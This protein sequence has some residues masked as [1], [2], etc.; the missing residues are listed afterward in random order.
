MKWHTVVF[1]VLLCTGCATTSDSAPP[2][3]PGPDAGSL[4]HYLHSVILER[5]GKF[6]E[7]LAALERAVEEDPEALTLMIRLMWGYYRLGDYEK[8]LD[9]SERTAERIPDDPG[10]WTLRGRILERL[11]RHDESAD[12]LRRAATLSPE[13]ALRDE[14]IIEA[15]LKSNDLVGA[16]EVVEGLSEAHPEDVDLRLRL[17]MV[18]LEINDLTNARAELERVVAQAPD[19]D[20]AKYLL[21]LVCLEL[22]DFAQAER[23]MAPFAEQPDEY[24]AAPGFLA[25][26]MNRQGKRV[27]A[28]G[29][30][31]AFHA[32][33]RSAPGDDIVL[34]YLAMREKDFATAAGSAPPMGAPIFGTLMRAMV[35]A[36]SGEPAR[37][38]LE[39]LDAVE[40]DVDAEIPE[41]FSDLR[42][43][44][45]DD[46]L[47][48]GF[49]A[50]FERLREDGRVSRTLETAYVRIQ[51][52]LDDAG[53][54]AQVA[55]SALS[56]FGG[57]HLLHTYGALAYERLGDLAAA[58]RHLR[59]CL[60]LQPDDHNTMNTLGYLLADAD[61]RLDEAEALVVKALELDPNN[62]FY[63]DSLGW[64]YYRR[65]EY[66]KAIEYIR[67]ALFG[68]Q[69]DDP[70][71]R[72][73]LGD[74]Y[75]GAGEMEKALAEWEKAL[76]LDPEHKGVRDKIDR[77]RR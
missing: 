58:E 23:F 11:E 49:L 73:H 44:A 55:E 70:T 21:G 43:A 13:N 65:G 62:P 22:D 14:A 4:N 48:E 76:R 8:A 9:V 54:A 28:L 17:A 6:E 39:T 18:Y 74:A 56:H 53:K 29:V 24:D 60:V 77:A 35:R 42:L 10:L 47:R 7:S 64:V 25:A 3:A 41:Y 40:G 38:I 67:R 57:D 36:E 26:A 30:L 20:R 59:A 37:P 31:K 75:A 50:P 15:E 63:L 61:M 32:S 45:G 12:A 52:M 16:L 68:M 33:R 2:G 27:E 1:S 51:L 66:D 34:M 69:S 19:N 5:E 72:D 71:L 46:E